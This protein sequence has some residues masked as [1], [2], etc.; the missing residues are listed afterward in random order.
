MFSPGWI[1]PTVSFEPPKET[2]HHQAERNLLG[3]GQD[4]L[5]ELPGVAPV[6]PDFQRIPHLRG[7]RCWPEEGESPGRTPGQ[8]GLPVRGWQLLGSQVTFPS[9]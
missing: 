2:A 3:Y 8:A 4:G 1:Y 5:R 9:D 7:N 6:I